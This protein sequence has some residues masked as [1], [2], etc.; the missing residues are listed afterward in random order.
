ML[1]TSY[2][3]NAIR[4]KDC[5]RLTDLMATVREVI[6]LTSRKPTTLH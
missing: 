3:V 5:A 1:L 6:E 2:G 4:L